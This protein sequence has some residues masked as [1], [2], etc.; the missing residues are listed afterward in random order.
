MLKRP[1]SYLQ[2]H[3]ATNFRRSFKRWTGLA[4]SALRQLLEG[5]G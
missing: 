2:F 3:D 1:L 4:P 5:L